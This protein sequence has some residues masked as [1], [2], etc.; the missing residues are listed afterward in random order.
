MKGKNNGKRKEI[1]II[2]RSA[3]NG[4]RNIKGRYGS[5]GNGGMEFL[6]NVITD[7]VDRWGIWKNDWQYWGGDDSIF[8]QSTGLAGG[9]LWRQ[10]RDHE[11]YW[12]IRVWLEELAGTI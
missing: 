4:C 6:I 5:G 12:V 2:G 11:L 9:N 3:G 10:Q 7:C 8:A 1:G